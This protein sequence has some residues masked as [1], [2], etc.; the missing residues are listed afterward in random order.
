MPQR[1]PA[2][3]AGGYRSVHKD[4]EEDE[5]E[6]QDEDEDEDGGGQAR[7]ERGGD[8]VSPLAR[9]SSAVL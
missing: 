7:A 8:A 1:R 6:D 5:D 2:A 9:A 3:A 4:P